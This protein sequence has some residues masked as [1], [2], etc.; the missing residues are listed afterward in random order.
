MLA[1]TTDTPTPKGRSHLRAR[2]ETGDIGGENESEKCD[3]STPGD[4]HCLTLLAVFHPRGGHTHTH[5]RLLVQT[6]ISMDVYE[7]RWRLATVM[8]FSCS[9]LQEQPERNPVSARLHSHSLG[10]SYTDYIHRGPIIPVEKRTI[11]TATGRSRCFRDSV[12]QQCEI[13]RYF[14]A[15]RAPRNKLSKYTVAISH[16]S[17]TRY[18]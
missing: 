15:F 2:M 8:P 17:V 9:I 6:Y 7:R 13:L 14:D 18:T 5:T 3:G 4:R 12:R 1:V 16:D 11:L 10:N